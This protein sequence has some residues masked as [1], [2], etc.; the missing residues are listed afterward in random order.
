MRMIKDFDYV[1]QSILINLY[2]TIWNTPPTC[3]YGYTALLVSDSTLATLG[4]NNV[5]DLKV[6]AAQVYDK[7]YPADANVTN[8]TDRR[9]SLNRFIS[10]H[11][12]DR[13]LASNEFIPNEL[14]SY[15]IP[16]TIAYSYLETMSNTLIEIQNNDIFNKRKGGSYIRI[17]NPNH[18]AENGVYHE[19]NTVLLYDESM[20]TDVLNK[21]IRFDVIDMLPEL[22]TNKIRGNNTMYLL[23]DGYLKYLKFTQQTE[24]LYK[25]NR[26]WQNHRGDEIILGGKYDFTLRM[27][28]IPAGTYEVRF[29]YTANSGRGVAQLFFDEKPCGIPLDMRIQADNAK[30][31]WIPDNR[32]E[33][34]GIENDKMMR[35]RGYYKGPDN[36]LVSGNTI[37]QRNL[38]DC[39]RKT[40]LTKT[41]DKT[42]PHYLRVKSV[43]ERLDREFQVDYMEFVP[44]WYL[45]VEGKD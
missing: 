18:S 10:Y 26:G 2:K 15:Y 32:T 7:M 12:L 24:T 14:L 36:I 30:I 37:T 38:K 5:D 42:E 27:P 13:E 25:I 8:I 41:F 22:A 17:I 35:N 39:L 9:N 19:I 3:K 33:D 21:R 31:G 4:I 16:N 11:L 40:L 34:G 28:P 20:E 23:P 43:E 45:T 1:Q 29:G 6:Y 44:L